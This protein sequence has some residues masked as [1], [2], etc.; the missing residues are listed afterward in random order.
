LKDFNKRVLKDRRTRPTP[1]LSWFT[2]FGRRKSLR[3][4]TDKQK[5]G[6]TDRY[7]SGVLASLVLILVLNVLDVLFTLTILDAGGCE[8]NFVVGS[9]IAL[10]GDRFWIWKLALS[11]FCIVLLCL[12]SN[13]RYARRAIIGTAIIY[14]AL[15]IYQYSL[16][17]CM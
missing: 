8:V 1:A 2:F 5:G 10:W 3:R 14:V 13:F 6:Y 7:T 4:E 9:A 11:S 12:H 15:A 16:L 17:R